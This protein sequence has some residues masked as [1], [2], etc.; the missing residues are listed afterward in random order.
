MNDTYLEKEFQAQAADVLTKLGYTLLSGEDCAKQRGG[1]YNVLLKDILREKLREMN[2]FEYGGTMYR[3][4]PANIER[5]IDELDVTLGDGLIKTSEKIYDALL[6]G[7]D[8]PETVGVGTDR[9]TLSFNLHFIDWE[10][11]ENNSFHVA[12]EFYVSNEAGDDGAKPDLVLFVNGIPL[13]II[14]CKAPDIDEDFAV[15]QHIRNQNKEYKGSIPQL[16]KFS[17]ILLATNKNA[18]KYATTGTGKKHWAP[19][20]EE[21]NE[22]LNEQLYQCVVGRTPTEQDKA[23]VSLYSPERLLKLTRYF[24]VYDANVKKIARYQQFFAVEE[25]IKTINTNDAVTGNRQSGVIWHTQGSGKS[26]TMVMLAKYILEHIKG[27]KVVIVTDRT[28]LDRQIEQTFSHTRLK[29]ARATSGKNLI[30]LLEKSKTEVV[31]ALI[32]K[33][34]TVENSGVKIHSRDV[35]VLVDESHRT[36]YGNLAAKMRL[37]FPNA[38]YIGFTGTPLMRTEKNTLA[39][40][41][42]LIHRYTISDGVNDK[43]TV[44]LIYEGRFVEQNV[45]EK[46]IDRWFEQITKRLTKKQTEDLKAKWAQL[47]RITSTEE[48]IRFIA[49][50]INT[51]FLEGYKR[52]GF[53]AMLACTFKRDA[54]RYL[55]CFEDMGD[56]TAAV[57]ISP[58]DM[59]EGYE[60]IDDETDDLVRKFWDK[61]MYR[62]GDAERYEEA[63]KN[64]FLDGEIDILI[65]C[66]K[67]LTGFDAPLTQVIYIDKELK[68]HGLL[69]AIARANRLHEGKDYGL[70][71]DYR[72]LLKPLDDAMEMYSGAGLDNFDGSEI[73]G[74]VVDV[75]R[76]VGTVR[77]AYSR[78]LDIFGH[79][80]DSRDTESLEVYLADAKLREEFCDALSAFGKALAMAL[81]SEK[82]YEALSK[83]EISIYK[84]AFV[85]FSKMR[86]SV[87]IRYADAI[88]N[89]E[90]E[91]QMQNLLDRY[92]SVVGLKQITNPVDILN[93]DELEKE[94][95]ELGSLRAKADAITSTMTKSISEKR[96]ENPA[97][98]DSFSRRIKDVLEEFKSRV[99][100]EAEYLSKMKSILE[101][102]RKGVSNVVY[103]E[104]VKGNLHAQAFYGVITAVLDGVIDIAANIET[105]AD[106]T[107]AIT[108]IIES[109]NTVDWEHNTDIHNRIAQQI[110]DLFFEYEQANKLKVPLEAIDKIIDNVKTVAL[111]RFR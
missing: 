41:G 34:N 79:L 102:F 67:L 110:D 28:E 100:S 23:L 66:G 11:P 68:E 50:D 107:L 90:Y 6:L 14:E 108:A 105:V 16:Y 59:R 25:I 58:P 8:L 20:K 57:V 54:V 77:E 13:G 91:P 32:N 96:D 47:K 19:W 9:R 3:F 106:I 5:A 48:R 87:K 27:S 89:A 37:V 1:R 56:L 88:D 29:P 65:V 24:I 17:Q 111:R 30:D 43:A 98:Y 62:Y 97:Y 94:L 70:I 4:S 2:S 18:V 74:A 21:R 75:I 86:R 82:V 83:E 45:D 35:F 22:W 44:P 71:V 38:C 60:E 61:M 51:H 80:R 10:Y 64:K 12:R 36:N 31:T 46:N 39:K 95:H 72:G 92:L 15:I 84:D 7:R 104:K 55:K 109:N 103:P 49:L 99:I 63:I 33:F 85:F 101:D 76:C 53:K 81:N 26:L 40:F 78:L 52:T 69:Q 73:K 93:R 42:K